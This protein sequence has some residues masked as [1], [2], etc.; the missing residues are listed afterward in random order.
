[1]DTLG[2]FPLLHIF[3]GVKKIP[4]SILGYADGDD[5][6]AAEWHKPKGGEQKRWCDV[7]LEKRAPVFV[8]AIF[9][10]FGGCCWAKN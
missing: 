8:G 10:V 3:P 2:R 7:Q 6:P 9:V 4:S 1:M 5:S